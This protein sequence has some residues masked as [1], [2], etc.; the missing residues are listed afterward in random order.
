MIAITNTIR[1]HLHQLFCIILVALLPL[2]SYSTTLSEFEIQIVDGES[3]EPLIGVNVFTD[4]FA[5]TTYSDVDGKAILKDMM[6]RQMV[7]FS[8]LGY[9]N[10]RLPFFKIRAQGGKIRMFASVVLDSVVVVGRRDD[11]VDEIPF[12]I[13]RITPEMIASTNPQTSADALRDHGGVFVQKSQ[14]GGGSPVIRGFEAN[15]V[16]LVVDGVR[17]NNAIYRSGHLQNAITIDNSI[18]EQIEVING[19]GSLMYGSEAL[20]GVVHF[21]T[22]DPQ[23][24][25]GDSKKDYRLDL[26]TYTRFSSANTEKTVHFDIDYGTRKWGSLTSFTYSDFGDLKAGANRPTEYPRMGLREFFVLIDNGV[27][28]IASSD[29]NIQAGTAYSQ[30]DF[31]QKIRFQPS[32]SLN[33]VLNFQYST[34]SDVPRYDALTDTLASGKDLKWAEWYYGPQKRLLASLKTRIL[35]KGFLS[36]KATLIA[37][38]QRIDEDRLKRK[39]LKKFKTYNLE[40][41]YVYSMTMDFDKN[42]DEKGRNVLSYGLDASYNTVASEAGNLN[43]N[44]STVIFNEPTRYPSGGSDMTSL[45]AYINYRWKSRDST[46]TIH[47]GGRYSAIKTALRFDST[48]VVDW[49]ANYYEEE[50]VSRNSSPTWG[51]GLTWNAK[52]QWQLRLLLATA[53]RAPNVDDMAKIR[54]KSGFVTV[55]N[56]ELEP[57]NSQSGEITL[58]KTFGRKEQGGKGTTFKLS[59]TAFYTNLNDIMV[60][61]LGQLP[62]GDTLLNVDDEDHR[63]QQIFNA[64]KGRI[65]G[66]SGNTLLDIN[67][68]WRFSAGIN[69]TRGLVDF[70]NEVIDTIVPMAHIPPLY[71]QASLQYQ[72]DRFRF[73]TVVRYN[74]KK[75]LEDYSVTDIFYDRENAIMVIDR[76]GTSDNLETSATCQEVTM[77]GRRQVVCGGSPAWTTLN[78]YTSV[79][80]GEKASIDFALENA[81]DIHYRP[82]SSGVSAAGRNFILTFRGNF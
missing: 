11:P 80:L 58:A 32:E 66:F 12:T 1:P 27:E 82:F 76:E 36:D 54:A 52:N 74:G 24:L 62:N 57:E 41:V 39:F 51:A 22:R 56:L 20:G 14:M 31:I 13:N 77:D 10:Q 23:L 47:T 48:D 38:F 70:K 9:T 25:F 75:A 79:K 8:Y 37:S 65:Y 69:Y 73:E 43:R 33:F 18:I 35:K 46:V 68:H 44:T 30:I 55:P 49:P 61:E 78:F 28:Q 53:F 71:G 21:R 6:H 16:L 72:N 60:R 4:D 59:A 67:S 17:M 5:F 45:G 3:G 64:Q 19:P 42:L 15:R 81:L 7:N 50:Q 63:V 26:G 2:Y 40:D 29:P 34:S